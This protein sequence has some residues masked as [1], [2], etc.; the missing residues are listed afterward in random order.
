MNFLTVLVVDALALLAWGK[1]LHRMD[2]FTRDKKNNYYLFYFIVSGI[3]LNFFLAM[4]LYPLWESILYLLTGLY[5]DQ[6]PFISH[7]LIVGPVEETTKFLVFVVLSGIFMSIKEPRDAVVQAGSVALGFAIMENFSYGM[8][9][10][11]G[12]LAIRSVIC[13]LGH[14]TYAGF[15]G[16]GW[17]AYRYTG[18]K[19]AKTTDKWVVVPL[20]ITAA[21]FHGAY[22]TLLD[23][24]H[25]YA[26]TL[27]DLTAAVL[28]LR[29]YKY[30]SENSPYRSFALTEYRRAIPVIDAGLRRHPESYV[31][32]KRMGIFKIYV[33]KYREALKNLK[34]AVRVNPRGLEARYYLGASLFLSGDTEKGL[35]T[36][37][38]V[39]SGMPEGQRKKLNR[40]L[41]KIISSTPDREEIY[42]RYN[43]SA[44]MFT[45]HRIAAETEYPR[46]GSRRSKPGLKRAAQRRGSSDIWKRGYLV[47]KQRKVYESRLDEQVAR[48]KELMSKLKD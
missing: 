2:T 8:E 30:T 5:M 36:M 42:S 38:S 12:T 22:N 17:G 13:T 23:Y 6:S 1:I 3:V 21:A 10:G 11:I 37:N 31:L 28:F 43:A 45:G 4:F 39:V 20:I 7:F 40:K 35:K 44:G 26:A 32:N 48:Y 25:F 34:R 24:N 18:V 47:K 19:G 33:R 29:F 9:W 46:T 14:I 16:L 15:W 41:K 27:L